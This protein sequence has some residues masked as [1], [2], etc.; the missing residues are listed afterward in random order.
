MTARKQIIYWGRKALLFVLS[1][2]V[3]SLAAFYI[4]RLAPGDPL[5][6]YYG[7]RVEKMSP[8]ER[9]WAEEIGRAHV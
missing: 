4:S 8:A 6:S 5:A 1:V 2:F 9:A 3:L 7:A